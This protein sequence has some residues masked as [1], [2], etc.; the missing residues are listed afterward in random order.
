MLDIQS[1]LLFPSA[2]CSYVS[3]Q[4]YIKT[5]PPVLHEVKQS[6]AGVC[7]FSFTKGFDCPLD[8]L[9]QTGLVW[10]VNYCLLVALRVF[11]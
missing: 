3:D 9:L 7:H 10:I 1:G 8:L 5:T 2:K 4:S 6:L 11:V